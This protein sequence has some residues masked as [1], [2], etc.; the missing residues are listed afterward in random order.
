MKKVLAAGLIVAMLI[1]CLP[2]YAESGINVVVDGKEIAFDQPPVIEDSRVLVPLRAI[3]EALDT[4]VNYEE[5]SKSV[6]ARKG[7]RVVSLKIGDDGMTVYDGEDAQNVKLDVPAKIMNGRTMVPVR[8]VSEGLDASV[9]WDG[10]TKTVYVESKKGKHNISS[11]KIDAVLKGDDGTGL[12][13]FYY[14]YP[15]IENEKN[16]TLIKKINEI[17]KKDA[18]AFYESVKTEYLSEA[19]ARHSYLKSEEAKEYA[20]YERYPLMAFSLDYSVTLDRN[21][22]LSITQTYYYDFGGAHPTTSKVS[23]TFDL[24]ERKELKLED[25]LNGSEREI[26]MAAFRAFDNYLKEELGEDPEYAAMVKSEMK[27]EFDNICYYLDDDSLVIYY[28]VYQVGPYAMGYPKARM[29]YENNKDWFKI[30][31]SGADLE[32]INLTLDGNPTT[33]YEWVVADKSDNINIG[34]EYASKNQL[35]AELGIG[36]RYKYEITGAGKGNAQVVFEYKRPWEE[37]ALK[38][39][40]YSLYVNSDNTITIIDIAE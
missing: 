36:G 32:K 11:V 9:K 7:D 16:D 4:N 21:N 24:K 25:I 18:E 40:T 27:K 13:D 2:V 26:E 39:I 38:T 17:Y 23:R 34:L 10:E 1:P 20:G 33:G 15:V 8:A 22:L 6:S 31:L 19:Q 29:Y 14:S 28:Q 3:F 30:D 12:V 37:K 5:I 35:E